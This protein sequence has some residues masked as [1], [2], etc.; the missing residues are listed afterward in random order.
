[1]RSKFRH[2]AQGSRRCAKKLRNGG[3]DSHPF[4]NSKRVWSRTPNSAADELQ[5]FRACKHF[6]DLSP[7]ERG[8][9]SPFTRTASSR[10]SLGSRRFLYYKQIAASSCC[11]A[12]PF[13]KRSRSAHLFACKRA[14][15]GSLSLPTFC[16]RSVTMIRSAPGADDPTPPMTVPYYD[17]ADAH[18]GKPRRIGLQRAQKH[19]VYRACRGTSDKRGVIVRVGFGSCRGVSPR[20]PQ[21]RRRHRRRHRRRRRPDAGQRRPRRQWP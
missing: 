7:A 11:V 20:H 12:P 2:F 13:R 5:A 19:P 10:T 16:G 4:N 15:N 8:A 1:M 21:N 9:Q 18:G 17:G 6:T 14:H 3:S